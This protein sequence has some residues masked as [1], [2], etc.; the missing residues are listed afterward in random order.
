MKTMSKSISQS[1]KIL[2]ILDILNM[3]SEDSKI[4]EEIQNIIN[5]IEKKLGKNDK[6]EEETNNS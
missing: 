2:N 4:K 3:T 6:K 5:K 1:D